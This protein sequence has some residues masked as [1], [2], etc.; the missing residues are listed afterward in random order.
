MKLR[1]FSNSR[2]HAKRTDRG[3]TLVELII[4][5]VLSVMVVGVIAAALITSL[6]VSSS[7]T[8]QV[9]D[10]SETGLISSFLFRDAQ[11]AGGIN[12]VNASPNGSLGVWTTASGTCTQAGALVLRFSWNEYTAATTFNAIEVVYSLDSATHTLTRK[13]CTNGVAGASVVL[14]RHLTSVVAVCVLVTTTVPCSGHPTSVSLTVNGSGVRAP[15]SSVLTASLRPVASQLAIVAPPSMPSGVIGTAYTSTTVIGTGFKTLPSV[16]WSV[17]GQ[18]AGLSISST[19]V[20]SGTPTASGSFNAV[21]TIADSVSSV[22][23]TYPISI[24]AILTV[25]WPVLPSTGD[26]GV[27][28]T[29]TAG[30]VTGGIGPYVW[31]FTAPQPTG[32]TLNTATGL[33]SGTPTAI[34]SFNPILKVTDSSAPPISATSVAFPV[35]INAA[36][37]ISTPSLPNGQVGVGYST[38]VASTGGTAPKTWSATGL[39]AGLTISAAGLISGTPTVAGTYSTAIVTVT[40]AIP[41]SVNKTYAITI[42]AAAVTCP[43]TVVGW[44][45]EYFANVALTGAPVLCRDDAN[46]I[47][48]DWGSGSPDATV[49]ADNFSVRWTRTQA[50]AAGYYTFTLGSDDG[51][52]LYIDGALVIDTW[53]DRSYATSPPYSV[54][55]ADGNHTI[56]MEFYENGGLAR[57]TLNW[58]AS[59]PPACSDGRHRM[60]WSV[61]QQR[62]TYRTARCVSRR[63]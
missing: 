19:G 36:L 48:L 58:V 5:L 6:N 50:F 25:T 32:L 14:G 33:V 7:T 59:T 10:S 52:R 37:V 18:P 21:V 53:G 12:P 49:P 51:G 39:P 34:G 61:L 41:T 60:A 17:T 27:A 16:V 9:N 28:Y 45:A 3:F 38:T 24:S 46:P 47:N 22:T 43:G 4:A 35:T 1:P 30:S 63:C 8:D 57:A 62:H 15:I 55:V 29:S 13:T 42:A 20:M 2:L 54:F 26:V 23:K 31:S 11:S 40:D 56:V 44:K